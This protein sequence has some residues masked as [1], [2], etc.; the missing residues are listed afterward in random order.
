MYLVKLLA[1]LCGITVSRLSF[2]HGMYDHKM[3]I[4]NLDDPERRGIINF[5]WQTTGWLSKQDIS[6]DTLSLLTYLSA[7]NQPTDEM[8]TLLDALRNAGI[9]NKNTDTLRAT[10]A[11][12]I[13]GTMQLENPE[14]GKPCCTGWII[15]IRI[16]CR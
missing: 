12:V 7:P 15:T 10:M 8:N 11:P 9:D 4:K 2:L 14:Q 3:L 13:A 6:A 1:D 5:L 16:K